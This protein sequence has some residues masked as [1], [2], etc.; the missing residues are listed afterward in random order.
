MEENQISY[1]N[2]NLNDYEEKYLK[3]KFNSN[4]DL[5]LKKTLELNNKVIFYRSVFHDNSKY[6][7]QTY[8]DYCLYKLA[9]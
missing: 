4:D 3:R 5:P 9:D 1:M 2:T 7:P 6:Y 8:L